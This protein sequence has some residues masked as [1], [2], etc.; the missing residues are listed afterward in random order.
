M[1]KK[2][3]SSRSDAVGTANKSI[4]AISSL[5][6]RKNATP[7]LHLV[8]LGRPARHVTRYRHLRH[9]EPEL[10]ELGVDSRR[11]PAVLC[12]RPDES[13]NLRSEAR[14]SRVALARDAR[15]VSSKSGP[16]PLGYRAGFDDD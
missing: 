3:Y 16:I 10:R 6:L 5:W 12:H 8:G 7:T 2:P 9:D 1:T 11:T 15:P 4:A 14:P 13:A